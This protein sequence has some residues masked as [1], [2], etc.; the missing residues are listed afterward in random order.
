MS[1]VPYEIIEPPGDR[2]P[3]LVSVPHCGTEFPPELRGAFRD[4]IVH[5]PPDT[6]WFVDRL[7]DFAPPLGITLIRAR[8]SR[9][10]I[11]LNRDPGG[12]ALYPQGRPITPL[13]PAQTFDGA[14]LYAQAPPDDAEIARRVERYHRPYYDAVAARLDALAMAHG[15]VLLFDAHSI[16]GQ[17]PAIQ[18]DPFPDLIL[19]DRDGASA[20]PA[21]VRAAVEALGE[22][23]G[24]SFAH[25]A[26]FKGGHIT[27]HFG[28][29]DRAVHA[30][31]LEMSQRIYMDEDAGTYDPAR[32]ARVRAL[33]ARLLSALSRT[34]RTF[35]IR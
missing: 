15:E 26:P 30:L 8:Y 5:K 35:A 3:I 29:P 25:D 10:V 31:Q 23:T 20:D 13:C 11:D 17:V 16:R 28:E 7:Y 12:S 27:R 19:G 22:S 18:P 1:D 33:L 24:F 14:P 9:Y 6:D 32:A 2:Q 4:E 21:L 34:L